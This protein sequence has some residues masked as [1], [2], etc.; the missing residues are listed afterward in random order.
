[1]ASASLKIEIHLSGFSLCRTEFLFG[2]KDHL[3]RHRIGQLQTNCPFHL[4]FRQIHQRYRHLCPVAGTHKTRQVRL[5][6][7]RLRSHHR[8]RHQSVVH[9]F[10][11]G[12][13]HPLPGR[14][15]IR[16]RKFHA[17]YPCRIRTQLRI[18]KSRLGKVRSQR[19]VYRSIRSFCQCLS[20]S[21]YRHHFL[22]KDHIRQ[23][24]ILRCRIFLENAGL[25]NTQSSVL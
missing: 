12:K 11:M 21:S 22:L 7:K 23:L 13:S 14:Q 17:H 20:I 16:Q 6:H 5:H 25:A 1:M 19:H 9:G 3:V 8:I 10:C 4:F 18:E 2:R 15:C 24:R